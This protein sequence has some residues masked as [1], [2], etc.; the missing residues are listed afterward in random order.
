MGPYEIDTVYDNGSVKVRKIDDK[1]LPFMVT[2]HQ[3]CLYKKPLFK[4]E[5]VKEMVH[6]YEFEL[7]KQVELSPPTDSS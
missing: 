3:L 1:M 7:V 5:F 4:Q 2:G 6:Q